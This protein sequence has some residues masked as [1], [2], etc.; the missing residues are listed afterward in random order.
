MLPNSVKNCS[1]FRSASSACLRLVISNMVPVTAR[2]PF[3]MNGR[4][5]NL[6]MDYVPVFLYPP[7][8]VWTDSDSPDARLSNMFLNGIEVF[9]INKLSKMH[10][11]EAFFDRVAEN[12]CKFRI[13]ICENAV[14]DNIDADK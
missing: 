4:P 13:Y 11:V 2:F 3:N 6:D 14:L 1:L 5:E 10:V 8:G 12:F 9:W 7:E